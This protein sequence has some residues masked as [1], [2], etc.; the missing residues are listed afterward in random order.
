[1]RI[2][3][4]LQYLE[5]TAQRL[6]DRIA[7]SEGKGGASLTFSALLDHA[8]RIGTALCR[9]G[10]TGQR[11]TM[12]MD[13][14]PGA[15]ATMLGALYAGAVYVP[16]DAAMPDARMRDILGRCRA[17]A[18]VCDGANRRAAEGFDLPVLD[19]GSLLTEPADDA[20]LALVRARQI[21]TDPMYIVFTSGS[22]GA[23][24]GVVGCHR[25]VIDYGEALTSAL[26]LDETAVFGCQAPLYLDAPLKEILTT[27]MKGATTY[28][29]PKRLFSFPVLL[30]DYL[31]ENRIN[32]VCWVS[33]V[34]STV[35]AL[36]GLEARPPLTLRRVVFGS[37]RLPLCYYRAWRQALPKA[38]F[39][40]LYGPTEAT[41]MSCVWRADRELLEDDSI[42]IGAPLDNTDLLL[43]DEERREIRSSHGQKSAVGEMY[44]RGSCLTLGYDHAT[45]QTAS[46]FVQNPLQNAYPETVYRTGDLAYYNSYGELVFAGR[47]DGQIKRMGHRIETGE[48]EACALRLEGVSLAACVASEGTGEL[49]LFYTGDADPKDV[50]EA[51][52]AYL[53]RYYMPSRSIKLD[54]L[55]TTPGGKIDRRALA[56][57]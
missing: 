10:L 22:T 46:A 5:E 8:R 14:S 44:L 40:Q 41:G 53:P 37:E 47:R 38:T 16:L 24:K 56:K 28:L 9:Q 13:R 19:V 25:A 1:M 15:I 51:L 2:K 27:L 6:P 54:V 39:Y 26:A 43:I 34:L 57:E 4:I 32:T 50:T 35:A 52:S 12:L 45:E 33:S 31:N 30:L 17:A 29:I 36:G 11:V 7:F 18:I 42:P 3:N 49:S 55:P 48:I 23:P 20:A 21:D